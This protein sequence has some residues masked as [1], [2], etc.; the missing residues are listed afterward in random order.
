MDSPSEF[1]RASAKVLSQLPQDLFSRVLP[2]TTLNGS[3][4]LWPFC[5]FVCA[6]LSTPVSWLLLPHSFYLH[7]SPDLHTVFCADVS[8]HYKTAIKSPLSF[9][10]NI[11]LP[12]AKDAPQDILQGFGQAMDS[13][14]NIKCSV[15]VSSAVDRAML[16]DRGCQPHVG[17][18][19]EETGFDL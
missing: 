8:L 10:I 17:N 9:G 14:R 19:S 3:L 12:L 1:N 13:Y 2:F 7:C 15:W 18:L 16:H 5:P 11:K 6:L 4:H